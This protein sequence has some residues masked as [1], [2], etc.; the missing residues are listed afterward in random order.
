[1]CTILFVMTKKGTCNLQLLDQRGNRVK[2]VKDCR[3]T[4]RQMTEAIDLLRHGATI[5]AQRAT[6]HRIPWLRWEGVRFPSRIAWF[7]SEL[8]PPFRI[9]WMRWE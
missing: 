5:E 6:L 4:D 9:P 2:V 1:V 7:R 3:T 8:F